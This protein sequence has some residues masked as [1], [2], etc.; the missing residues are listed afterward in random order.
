MEEVEGFKRKERERERSV[1]E[2]RERQWREE[3]EVEVSKSHLYTLMR[4]FHY[5]LILS[6]TGRMV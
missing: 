5:C 3:S 2:L 6:F 4:I 1:W